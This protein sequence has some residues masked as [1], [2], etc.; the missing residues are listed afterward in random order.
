MTGLNGRLERTFA[1]EG[2]CPDICNVSIKNIRTAAFCTNVRLLNQGDVKLHDIEIDGVYDES[3]ASA[4]MDRG[5]YAVRVGDVRL[6]G[7][8][9]ATVEE[10]YNIAIRNVYS[11]AEIAAVGLAGD[12]KNLTVE[13]V[14]CAA[15]TAM[16]EDRRQG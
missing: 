10:T 8:R 14:R 12:M 9:H 7:T 1:V 16:F 3:E 6:Y 2:I 15:E 5:I 11:R 13:D 4:H